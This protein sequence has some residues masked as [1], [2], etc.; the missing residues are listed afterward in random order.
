M[1]WFWSSWAASLPVQRCY[2]AALTFQGW[3]MVS[4]GWWAS[5]LQ[6]FRSYFLWDGWKGPQLSAAC[7]FPLHGSRLDAA[8]EEITCHCLPCRL[9]LA[10][11]SWHALSLTLCN[12]LSWCRGKICLFL[13]FLIFSLLHW[14]WRVKERQCSSH[15]LLPCTGGA[16]RNFVMS[17]GI[18]V[19]ATRGCFSRRSCLVCVLEA[20][21]CRGTAVWKLDGEGLAGEPG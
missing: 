3:S 17:V 15:A 6:V 8:G 11:V 18:G 12:A 16:G 10:L 7:D 5:L 1:S 14:A 13:S 2:V 19:W 4:G 20:Q 21:L 9:L